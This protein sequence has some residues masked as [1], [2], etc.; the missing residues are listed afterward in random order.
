MNFQNRFYASILSSAAVLN[1]AGGMPEL[2]NPETRPLFEGV[3]VGEVEGRPA[4]Y[5]V[6]KETCIFITNQKVSFPYG[7]EIR[8]VF[9]RDVGCDNTVD[10]ASDKYGVV[11]GRDYFVQ[12]GTVDELDFLLEQGQG[13]VK[14]E[15]RIK[16]E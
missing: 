9:I 14:K 4:R 3:Y 15:N 13:L 1:C 2:R 7:W 10:S 5:T 6:E 11:R 8:T 12:E 16:E